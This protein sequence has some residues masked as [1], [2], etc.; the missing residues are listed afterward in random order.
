MA[1]AIYTTYPQDNTLV[2]TVFNAKQIVPINISKL[3]NASQPLTEQL[4]LGA[5]SIAYIVLGCANVDMPSSTN[6]DR[7]GLNYL[8]LLT[9]LTTN[10]ILTGFGLNSQGGY[11]PT[12]VGQF[13]TFRINC[14]STSISAYCATTSS[15]NIIFS[16]YLLIME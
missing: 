5:W 13:S 15:I 14:D 8:H 4:W 11:T 10:M 9:P 6:Y 12:R 16:G 3:V 2:N 7:C 1:E